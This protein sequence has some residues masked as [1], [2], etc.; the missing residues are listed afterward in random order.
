[1]L[2]VA[3]QLLAAAKRCGADAA[4]VLMFEG[5]SLEVG[6][7]LNEIEK[8]KQAREKHLGLR[9]FVGDRSAVTSSADFSRDSLEKLAADTCALARALASDPH[10]GLPDPAALAKDLPEM[11]LFDPAVAEIDADEAI[12]MAKQAES[13]AMHADSR[14]TNSEGAEVDRSSADVL[15][16][17]SA[18]FHGTYR[19][20]SLSLSVMPV[21][22]DGNG[23]QRDYWYSAQRYRNKLETPEAIGRKAAQ[24]A[25]RRLGGRSIPTCEVPVVFDPE[26]ASSLIR[27]LASAVSAYAIYKGVSFL[28]DKLGARIA[29]DFVSIVDD[30]RLAGGLGSKPF[31]GEGVATRRTSVVESGVLRSFLCDTYSG[32]KIGQ[33]STGNASRSVGSAP[34]VAPTNMYLTPGTASPQEIIASVK[35]GLYVTELI[36]FGVN[37]TNGDYSRGAVGIWIENG[38]L[39]YPVEEITV[40]GNLLQ[41]FE[42]IEVIGSDLDL[43]SNVRAP[44]LKV[45]RMTVAGQ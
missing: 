17:S 35:S 33:A 28:G 23:M 36:G 8:I 29:P 45:A 41:M 30:G 9:V 16:A 43:R 10:A 39:A 21:A 31:D 3:E 19:T 14:I 32:R 18:G 27:H 4:D 7:R 26:M 13:A 11:N 15:Y 2:K 22:S 6:V 20:S 37:A 24:R 40:A 42:Q 5:D 44:T 38:A 12:D 34:H 25:A 1:M